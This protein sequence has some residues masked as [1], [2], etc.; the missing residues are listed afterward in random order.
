MNVITKLIINI[1]LIFH[2]KIYYKIR[3][4]FEKI[5]IFINYKI[6]IF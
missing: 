3:E 4:L 1:C 6:F 2:L 5:I